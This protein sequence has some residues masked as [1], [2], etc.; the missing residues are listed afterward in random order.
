MN[1][2]LI[3]L[4]ESKN[5]AILAISNF[6]SLKKSEAHTLKLIDLFKNKGFKIFIMGGIKK[7][8]YDADI[9]MEKIENI[10][11]ESKDIIFISDSQEMINSAKLASIS[12]I[13]LLNNNLIDSLIIPDMRSFY[14][15]V[16]W[17]LNSHPADPNKNPEPLRK[18]TVIIPAAGKGTRLGFDKPKILYPFLGNT[19]LEILYQKLKPISEK[20]IV[21][22]NPEGA[23]LIN[24]HVLDKRI[25]I[26]VVTILNSL[27]TADTVLSSNE[28]AKSAYDVLIIWGDQVGVTQKALKEIVFLHQKNQADLS[29]P[30]RLRK[31]PYIHLERDE[32]GVIKKV[33]RK[34]F[35]DIMPQF[36]ENDTGVFVIKGNLLYDI[37]NKMKENYLKKGDFKEE[38]DF[39]NIIPK[40]ADRNK[41]LTSSSIIEDTTLGF[42][43]MEEVAF[44]EQ[45]I[46]REDELT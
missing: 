44:H 18:V 2:K 42:N 6:K 27:G 13:G 35:N 25:D 19:A 37:L 17:A 7:T 30:T 29:M 9:F 1:E 21:I 4:F 23:P 36:G 39:L 32:K 10:G 41:I 43:T 26:E 38:F 16:N 11:E 14:N 28:V 34:R 40:V 22:G 33:L 46:Q 20:I 3:S 8:K 45:R 15:I 12:T 5:V 24:D 31:D